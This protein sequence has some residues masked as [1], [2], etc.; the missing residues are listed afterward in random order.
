MSWIL[1]FLKIDELK[2][3]CEQL[4]V[5]MGVVKKNVKHELRSAIRAK[6]GDLAPDATDVFLVGDGVDDKGNAAKVWEGLRAALPF[7]ALFK[8]DRQ[9]SDQDVEAQYPLKIAIKEA[10]AAKAADLSALMAFVEQEVKKVADL[11][12]KKLKEMDPAV[13]AT[14]NPKFEKPNWAMQSLGHPSY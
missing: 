7:Y 12:L 4:G 14:L 13:A 8:S 10:L 1:D 6:V 5:D 9:S 2:E 3:R 11:T